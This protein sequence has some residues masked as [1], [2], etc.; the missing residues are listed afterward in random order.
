MLLLLFLSLSLLLSL[1]SSSLRFVIGHF[2]GGEWLFVC[3]CG[4]DR[5]V[6][7]ARWLNFVCGGLI[8]GGIGSRGGLGLGWVDGHGRRD[9]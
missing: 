7:V 3:V 6:M 2:G 9:T 1:S 8:G 4:F 5:G